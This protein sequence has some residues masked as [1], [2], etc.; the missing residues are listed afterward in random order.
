MFRSAVSL[1]WQDNLEFIDA[2]AAYTQSFPYFGSVTG[3]ALEILQTV[4]MDRDKYRRFRTTQHPQGLCPANIEQPRGLDEIDY[5]SYIVVPVAS[6]RGQPEQTRLGVLH[7]DTK[8]FAVSPDELTDVHEKDGL[9]TGQLRP[10]DLTKYANNVYDQ[11][12]IGVRYLEEMR[13]VLVPVLQ[14]YLK[15]RQGSA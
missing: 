3:L 6:Y 15:C 8:L 5:L 14:L 9:L 12:D 1:K 10:A 11:N 7:V 2:A 13:A 4:V